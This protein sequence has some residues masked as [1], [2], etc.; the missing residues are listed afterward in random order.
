M[1]NNRYYLRIRNHPLLQ[2]GKKKKKHPSYLKRENTKNKKIL[3]HKALINNFIANLFKKSNGRK[4]IV[5][6]YKQR[7]RKCLKEKGIPDKSITTVDNESQIEDDLHYKQNLKT[8]GEETRYKYNG[9][10]ADV[11]VSVDNLINEVKPL[12]E[13]KRIGNDSIFVFTITP[14]GT[15]SYKFSWT[16]RKLEN[17][18]MKNGYKLI[19]INVPSKFRLK[20]QNNKKSVYTIKSHMSDNGFNKKTGRTMTLF[21]K[22]IKSY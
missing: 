12:F 2:I 18:A 15:N 1:I 10:W 6:S 7:T 20:L 11:I 9:I 8:F 19:P 14:R 5:D 16:D 22:C 13:R 4:L 21:Y 3:N 17:L